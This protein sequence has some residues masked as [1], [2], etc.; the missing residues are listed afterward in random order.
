MTGPPARSDR[1]ATPAPCYV[2][3]VRARDTS[4]EAYEVQLA[5]VRALT[6]EQRLLRGVAWCEFAREARRAGIRTR[7]PEYG[8]AEVE[9]ALYRLELADDSL[10]RAAWPNRP[11]L[12]P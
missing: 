6:P 4:A 12:A 7:H 3:I 10:F 9:A 11:L 1:P 5:Q 8:P 2:F